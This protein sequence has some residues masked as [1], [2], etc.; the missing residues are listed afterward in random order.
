MIRYIAAAA[1]V[2][3]CSV[4]AKAQRYCYTL[5]ADMAQ[6]TDGTTAFS[7]GNGSVIIND[8]PEI[9]KPPAGLLDVPQE[10]TRAYIPSLLTLK[11]LVA[12][13]YQAKRDCFGERPGPLNTCHKR[14]DIEAELYARGMCFGSSGQAMADSRWQKCE[15]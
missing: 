13:A 11:E 10:T 9:W 5:G 1:I 14:N 8:P 2:L 6:C 15:R 4:E 3:A 7:L 12:A